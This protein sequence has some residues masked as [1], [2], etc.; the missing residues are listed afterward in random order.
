[1]YPVCLPLSGSKIS[2]STPPCLPLTCPSTVHFSGVFTLHRTLKPQNFRLRRYTMHFWK[3]FPPYTGSK[4]SKFSPAA[5]YRCI[6]SLKTSMS[7]P[8]CLPLGSKPLCLPILS[9]P[10]GS[11]SACLPHFVYPHR[12]KIS[13][14]THFVYPWSLNQHVYPTLSTPGPKSAKSVCLPHFVY[15]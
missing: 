6:L 12:L 15:P 11:K 10:L 4:T 9:T 7:T 14:S 8:L 3:C 2:M 1:M 13:M 5:L